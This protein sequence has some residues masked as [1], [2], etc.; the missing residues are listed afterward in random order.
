MKMP[1]PSERLVTTGLVVRVRMILENSES[2][3]DDIYV[4][5]KLYL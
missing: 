4:E 5:V 1:T 2:V 3:I